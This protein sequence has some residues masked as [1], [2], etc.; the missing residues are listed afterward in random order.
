[1]QSAVSC[2]RC[3][4]SHAD[5]FEEVECQAHHP[6]TIEGVSKFPDLEQ[7]LK[8]RVTEIKER[9]AQKAERPSAPDSSTSLSSL[10]YVSAK[11]RKIQ[12]A[13]RDHRIERMEVPGLFLVRSERIDRQYMV[14][15]NDPAECSCP[16]F[17]FT[18]HCYHLD[19]VV[20]IFGY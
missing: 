17:A 4:E 15:L 8:R 14:S 19:A 9:T 16:G 3:G 7:E 12:A 13:L 6:A 1:M 18:G 11:E 2:K 10:E 20:S 5:I